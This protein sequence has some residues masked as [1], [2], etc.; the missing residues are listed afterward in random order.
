LSRLSISAFAACFFG[1][2]FITVLGIHV[3]FSFSFLFSFS[4]F[5]IRSI[6]LF[7]AQSGMALIDK[8]DL[9]TCTVN[10]EPLAV[11]GHPKI[12]LR[13][14]IFNSFARKGRF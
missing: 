13:I 8:A 14:S 7:Q 9:L 1:L 11:R 2:A 3:V 5:E 12:S 10:P 4:F 6:R